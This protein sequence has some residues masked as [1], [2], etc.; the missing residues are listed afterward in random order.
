MKDPIKVHDQLAEDY[1]EKFPEPSTHLEEFAEMMPE[2][3]IVLDAGCGA[4]LDSNYLSSRGFEV[5]GVD[6]S[7]KMLE[8]AERNF[9]DIEFRKKD[10]RELDFEKNSFDGVVASFSLIYIPKDDIPGI[11]QEFAKILA[12]RGLLFLG[13]Q[14]G[15]SRE[16]NVEDPATE[17]EVFMNIMSEK[18]I[19]D[20]LGKC[21]FSIEKNMSE[22]PKP[23]RNLTSINSSLLPEPANPSNLPVSPSSP[24]IPPACQAA[25]SSSL[26]CRERSP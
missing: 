9:P 24:G 6:L 10:L 8:V 5:V 3:G 17:G 21:G 14:K 19:Q 12:E 26:S 23:A 2:E 4:G 13:L 15:R 16:T 7:D 11:I 1:I 25:T 20:I 18:E 22:N